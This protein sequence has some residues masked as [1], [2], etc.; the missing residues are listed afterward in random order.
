MVVVLDT[1][2]VCLIKYGSSQL[3]FHNNSLLDLTNVSVYYL[4]T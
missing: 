4:Y 1:Q 3:M 2:K